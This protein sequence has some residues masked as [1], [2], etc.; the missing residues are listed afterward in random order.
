MPGYEKW[1]DLERKEVM[2]VLDSGILMRYGF[3]AAR[4]GH[5]K[6]KEL[7]SAVCS[8]FGCDHAQLTSSGTAALTTALNAM[9]IGYG[10]EVI[11]PAF[12]FVALALTACGKQTVLE[13]PGPLFGR[14]SPRAD[15]GIRH[16][17]PYRQGLLRRGKLAGHPCCGQRPG[18]FLANLQ[19]T[20]RRQPRLDPACLFTAAERRGGLPERHARRWPS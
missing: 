16:R 20:K 13:R 7:E 2:D 11:M 4:K 18:H 15:T 19:R 9:G 17:Q 8:T 1:S 12:T 3:D 6:S 10:D 5:W 14:A